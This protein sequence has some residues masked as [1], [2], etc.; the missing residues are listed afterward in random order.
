MAGLDKHYGNLGGSAEPLK[1]QPPARAAQPAAQMAFRSLAP[2]IGAFAVK[3]S[4]TL[5]YR[6]L[7]EITFGDGS[8]P[9]FRVRLNSLKPILRIIRSPDLGCGESYMDGDWILERGDLGAFLKMVCRNEAEAERSIPGRAI[10]T[11][12]AVLA[13][14]GRNNPRKSRRNAAHHYDIGNDLYQ[15]FLD[16]GMNYSCAFFKEPDQSLRDAQLNKL[17]TTIRRL[18]VPKEARVLDIGS[19]WGELTRLLAAETEATQVTGITLAEAQLELARKRA[20]EMPGNKPDYELIDYRVHAVKN[21]GAYERIVSIGMFEHV[22]AKHF[23][24]YFDAIR[25]M[26]TDG[27]QA[28]VHSIMRRE[29]SETS[30]WIQKYIFP[31]GYIPTLDDTVSAAREAGL[32]LAHEPFIHE[33]F[34]YAE[35]LRRWRKNFNEAWSGLDHDRYDSRFQRMWNFYLAGSEAGFDANGLFVGQVLVRK[36]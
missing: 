8:G 16:E 28:V 31:G 29:R 9:R 3:G 12:G 33:S 15:A 11:A 20:A 5:N 25:R 30:R 14:G 7:D 17:R 35:T 32:K 18:D 2:V 19:G 4:L 1:R 26:L 21:P 24:E 6:D 34:H 10:R 27:G 13:K 22:G 23:V 36:I